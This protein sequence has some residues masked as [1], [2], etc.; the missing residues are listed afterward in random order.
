MFISMVF[1][2]LIFRKEIDDKEATEEQ[3]E[4]QPQMQDQEGTSVGMKELN[5]KQVRQQRTPAQASMILQV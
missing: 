4:D 5:G 3:T 2:S 1:L